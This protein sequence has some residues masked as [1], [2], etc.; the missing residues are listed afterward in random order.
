MSTESKQIQFKSG[1]QT[2][3]ARSFHGRNPKF[4]CPEMLLDACFKYLECVDEN[5][6]MAVELVKYQ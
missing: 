3:K 1:N 4:E 5:L 6:L 2:G